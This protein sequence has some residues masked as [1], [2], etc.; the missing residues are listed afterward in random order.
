MPILIFAAAI[1][2]SV[3]H[4]AGVTRTTLTIGFFIPEPQRA[5]VSEPSPVDRRRMLNAVVDWIDR[6]GGIAGRRVLWYAYWATAEG[7]SLDPSSQERAACLSFEQTSFAAVSVVPTSRTFND[8]LARRA[9]VF[10]PDSLHDFATASY[11]RAHRTQLFAPS[12]LSIDRW[13]T[14]VVDG[15]FDRGFLTGR[16]RIGVISYDDPSWT[17]VLRDVVSPTIAKRGGHLVSTYVFPQGEDA[18]TQAQVVHEMIGSP[19]VPG[20]VPGFNANAVDRVLFLSGR[21]L[22]RR[23]AEVAQTF[24]YFPRYG[25]ST[26]NDLADLEQPQWAGALDGAEAIG[27]M[28]GRDVNVVRSVRNASAGRCADIMARADID[29]SA[30]AAADD[31]FAICDGLFFLRAA[32]KS[33]TQVTSASLAAAVD[34]LGT[35]YTG[36]RTFATEFGP[37][38]HDGASS[39]RALRFD[40]SCNCFRYIGSG[41][42][43]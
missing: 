22:V 16:T 39:V 21:G 29:L 2:A 12:D 40:T 9:T 33:A 5:S 15:L 25:L 13:S 23:F 41:G 42:T 31:A 20:A 34:R 43:S 3:A 6:N 26:P 11:M 38:R 28:P 24:R 7:D 1:P 19:G 30:P 8:C 27:W 10:I 36:A 4:A 37:R 18:A 17:R 14:S 32:L 35:S